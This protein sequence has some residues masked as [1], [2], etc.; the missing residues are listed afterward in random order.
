MPDPLLFLRLAAGVAA[1]STNR[2]EPASC[3]DGGARVMKG[4]SANVAVP[5]EHL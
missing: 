5:C 1:H 4:I 3:G 2:F